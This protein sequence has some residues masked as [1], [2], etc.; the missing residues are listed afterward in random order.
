M[1]VDINEPQVQIAGFA[2]V[3]HG[4]ERQVIRDVVAGARVA[5]GPWAGV[6]QARVGVA[7]ASQDLLA[8][9]VG[10]IAWQVWG[11]AEGPLYSLDDVFGA[12]ASAELGVPAFGARFSGGPF[13]SVGIDAA[14]VS[15]GVYYGSEDMVVSAGEVFP[16]VGAR[17][18]A[19]VNWSLGK[20]L[21]VRAEISDVVR[22]AS[23]IE[24]A[25][26]FR[27]DTLGEEPPNPLFVHQV[28][29]AVTIAVG[30]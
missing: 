30:R 21:A 23:L 20:N 11:A 1:P 27:S 17:I 7:P 13:L 10:E 26:G 28:A 29:L 22:S 8:S 5:R 9:T 4:F 15:R 16:A 2:G 19:G 3:T 25:G 24:P 12:S 18:G 14:F 6:V